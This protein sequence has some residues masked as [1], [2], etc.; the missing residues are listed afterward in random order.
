MPRGGYRPG[1]GGT[2]G[3]QNARKKPK[4]VPSLTQAMVEIAEKVAPVSDVDMLPLDWMLK[5]IRD[6]DTEALRR[7]RMAIAA[8]PYLHPKVDV[9]GKKE[10]KNAAAKVAETGKF[11]PA[12]PPKLVI[13][14]R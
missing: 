10:Q 7:D 6:K 1:G 14:N 2:L 9:A 13:N 4:P 8:A 5:V 11:A 3:N 12:A